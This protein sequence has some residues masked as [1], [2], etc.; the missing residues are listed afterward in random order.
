MPV[1]PPGAAPVS[2]AGSE[3]VAKSD[4]FE[5][6]AVLVE[7]NSSLRA[8]LRAALVAKGIP[9][10]LVCK[11]R[12]SFLEVAAG[13]MLDVILC[14]ANTIGEEFPATLQRLRRNDVGGNPFA[15]VIAT[16]HDATPEGVRAVL[17]SG[18]DDLL[19]KPAPVGRIV[20]RI[21]NLA[22]ERRPFVVTEG[23][24]GPSRRGAR[25]AGDDGAVLD[26]PNTLRCRVVDKM[27]DERLNRMIDQARIGLRRKMVQHPL[28]GIDRLIHR[29]LTS[30][31]QNAG[32]DELR[33]D[34]AYLTR[35]GEELGRRYR[36][37]PF[38]HI[39]DL[40][41]ALADLA[42]RIASRNPADLRQVDLEPLA[43]LGEVIRRAVAAATGAASSQTMAR[44]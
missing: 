8:D 36:G 7:G 18:V 43:Q 17:D 9:N 44:H 14:D 30:G 21:D 31:Q 27:G 22:R 42:R 1:S 12:E 20:E 2:G 15:T 11:D 35:L 40:A 16:V 32:A 25:R 6:R 13:E 5:V 38:A 33:R 19:L 23:Y 4:Y 3:D 41:V 24:V 39:A 29:A 10:P 28:L 37:T 34:F 26:V